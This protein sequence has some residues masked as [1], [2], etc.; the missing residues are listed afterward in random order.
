MIFEVVGTRSL[1]KDMTLKSSC[2]VD[3][4]GID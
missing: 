2:D 1:V 4:N 3:N